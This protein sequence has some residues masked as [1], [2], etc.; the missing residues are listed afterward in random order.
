[1]SDEPIE[2]ADLVAEMPHDRG[3]LLLGLDVDGV[4]APIVSRAERSKLLPGVLPVLRRLARCIPVAIVSGRS[5]DDL[6]SLY[7]FPGDVVVVGSHGLETRGGPRVE[8][9]GGERERLEALRALAAE[10]AT[11]AGSGAW[12]EHK[13]ASVVLHVRQAGE[14]SGRNATRWLVD[15]AAQIEGGHV[16]TGHAVVELLARTTSK[17]DAIERLRRHYGRAIVAF[18][19]DDL[20]DEEVFAGLGPRDFG[21]RVGPGPTVARYRLAGP[22]Q[23]LTWLALLS[24]TL[25]PTADP[26]LEI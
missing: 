20:T 1:V 26:A 19:G 10:A 14:Q 6:E 23:V 17:A 12:L 15:H 21:V 13:P 11:I 8:L 9:D 24:S 25:S 18:A 5:V 22:P 16:K 4:L 3:A 7:R 2:P